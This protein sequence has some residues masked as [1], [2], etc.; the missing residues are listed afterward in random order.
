MTLWAY[1]DDET[2]RVVIKAHSGPVDV[3][4]ADDLPAVEHFWG[5]L[6]TLIN[7]AKQQEVSP[8]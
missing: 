2:G 7:A 4:V 8:P 1:R 3:T 6:G 5:E